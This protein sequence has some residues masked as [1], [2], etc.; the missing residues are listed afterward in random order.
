[1]I[2]HMN[3]IHITCIGIASYYMPGNITTYAYYVMRVHLDYM[4]VVTAFLNNTSQNK[5]YC[6]TYAVRY[7]YINIIAF[8]YPHKVYVYVCSLHVMR[9]YT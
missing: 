1:M 7:R 4:V 6:T 5:H 2:A 8:T 9:A 3:N